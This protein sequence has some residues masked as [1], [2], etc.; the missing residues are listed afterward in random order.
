M[1]K[2]KPE[3]VQ[4]G[5]WVEWF[6]VTSF[7]FFLMCL[8]YNPPQCSSMMFSLLDR[9]RV[10]GFQQKQV[11]LSFLRFSIWWMGYW[12]LQNT[13]GL[14]STRA[15][16]LEKWVRGLM[17]WP[18]DTMELHH[19]VL[20]S[21][22]HNACS[23]LPESIQWCPDVSKSPWMM[24][25]NRIGLNWIG[26]M[27]SMLAYY[28]VYYSTVYVLKIFLNTLCKHSELKFRGNIWISRWK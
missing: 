27:Q 20:L 13:D 21:W 28:T 8:P 1:R 9:F 25:G 11:L 10:F 18:K 26:C 4:I 22:S 14:Q 19:S 2:W 15:S 17:L 24:T 12:V 7:Y 5:F 6:P 23:W 3:L 16:L